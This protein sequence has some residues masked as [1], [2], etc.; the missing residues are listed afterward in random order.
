[1]VVLSLSQAE[2]ERL[3]NFNNYVNS[4][5]QSAPT[6]VI[7]NTPIL[8]N[9]QV[10]SEPVILIPVVVH[11]IHNTDAQ[12]ISDA[13]IRSQ[14]DVLNEDFRRANSDASQTPAR[15]GTADTRIQFYLACK[16]P[17]GNPTNGIER[18]RTSAIGFTLNNLDA[19]KQ[20]G[21]GLPAWDSNKYLNIW[22][23]NFIDATLGVATFP[24]SLANRP[25]FDG[26][27]VRFNAL[28][29]TGNLLPAF[30]LGRTAT[31]EVGH[32]LNLIHI[33]GDDDLDNYAPNGA[34]IGDILGNDCNGT[35]E[36]ADTPNQAISTNGCPNVVAGCTPGEQ[37]MFM[38]YM[39][40]T[41]DR[42]MNAFT[43]GQKIRMRANFDTGQPRG[44]FQKQ[45]Y[46]I[47]GPAILGS[48]Q[49]NG[50]Q[51]SVVF[52]ER[53]YTLNGN[54]P[55]GAVTTWSVGPGVTHLLPPPV[56]CRPTPVI[57]FRSK[58]RVSGCRR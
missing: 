43:F 17:D 52:P 10:S 27:V 12:N 54:L 21:V 34:Y 6:R 18:F 16:D 7:P 45:E 22:S 3:N 1:M 51:L 8:L 58:K 53:T 26:I 57:P 48:Y 33:W 5:Q 30:N 11:V 37:A 41:D 14:I 28:G 44:A 15:F 29:K 40:Y 38:N 36:V 9:Q 35:D 42:C 23:C 39:D 24:I 46:S 49:I 25:N 56:R 4:F 32:W 50:N 55:A 19:V 47:S 20:A 31:H 13:Q 2:I